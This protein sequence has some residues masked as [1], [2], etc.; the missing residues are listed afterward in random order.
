MEMLELQNQK[1]AAQLAQRRAEVQDLERHLERTKRSAEA[2]QRLA[3]AVKR[4]WMQLHEDLEVLAVQCGLPQARRDVQVDENDPFLT[5]LKD[6]A[7]HVERENV[8]QEGDG[9]LEGPP[10]TD[11]TLRELEKKT[12]ETFSAVL[13]A[14]LSRTEAS[15]ASQDVEDVRANAV[16]MAEKHRQAA[17]ESRKEREKRREVEE[18]LVLAQQ[19]HR[20]LQ[21]TLEDARN[22]LAS[23][24]RKL[25][26]VETSTKSDRAASSRGDEVRKA[27]D[28]NTT[29]DVDVTK[30]Q[31]AFEEEK[32]ALEKHLE[33]L[34]KEA[35]NALLEKTKT[36]EELHEYQAKYAAAERYSREDRM[37]LQTRLDAVIAERDHLAKT[38]HSLRME[39]DKWMVDKMKR[40]SSRDA[41]FDME[42]KIKWLEEE[43][44]VARISRPK[45]YEK[46]EQDLLQNVVR[47]I[48]LSRQELEALTQN[49][50]KAGADVGTAGKRKRE[51][52]ELDTAMIRD[53]RLEQELVH[54][55]QTIADLRERLRVVEEANTAARLGQEA[56]K[57]DKEVKNLHTRVTELED[58]LSQA[59]EARMAAEEERDAFAGELDGVAMALEDLSTQNK[60]LLE[61]LAASSE[62]Q[63]QLQ[64]ASAKQVTEL[65]QLQKTTEDMEEQFKVQ[66][67]E[68]QDSRE[69]ARRAES[70]LSE[71]QDRLANLNQRLSTMEEQRDRYRADNNTAAAELANLEE[72]YKVSKETADKLRTDQQ[73]AERSAGKDRSRCAIL[74]SETNSLKA[75]VERLKGLIGKD[76]S[77]VNDSQVKA[78][79]QILKCPVCSSRDKEVVITKCYHLF[80]HQCIQDNLD[81]RHRKCPGCGVG[82][83]ANDVKRVY[84][85]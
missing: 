81:S 12:K 22:E 75:Q 76:I 15:H 18:A 40:S 19:E 63:L 17:A 67:H 21:N 20:D 73:A 47:V 68:V 38:A 26:S 62:D 9:A 59:E 1:L 71:M 35:D 58:R 50:G 41:L 83:G 64:L 31:A 55:K 3:M 51:G 79:R 13:R 80:C 24:R 53:G 6:D 36:S 60:R 66:A 45:A 10:T 72:Q 34:R 78:L 84:L 46:A 16:A 49:L 70:R 39:R 11:E 74:E 77:E 65:N 27:T 33:T 25:A 42:S 8:A 54:S 28:G 14:L 7:H 4:R 23:V 69:K 61:Q 37:R 2:R 56:S 85:S 57:L 30:V 29:S 32:A 44:R 5:L 48:K 52:A 43:L 82:F